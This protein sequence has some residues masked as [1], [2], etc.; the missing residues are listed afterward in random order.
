MTAADAPTLAQF[1]E[2]WDL[3]RDPA[4]SGRSEEHTSALQSRITSRM[5]SSA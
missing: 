5:P 3:F 4:L 1:F 2:A